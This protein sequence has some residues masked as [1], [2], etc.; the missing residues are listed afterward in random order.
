MFTNCTSAL[1][2]SLWRPSRFVLIRRF[3]HSGSVADLP[4]PPPL[5]VLQDAADSAQAREWIAKFQ[6]QEIPRNAV[7]LA[8]SRS[9]G[10]GGQN[11]NK[12]N[13]KATLRCSLNS[14][15]LPPWSK[16]YLIKST[17]Y[18]ASTHTVQITSTVYRSQAQNIQECLSKLHALIVSAA[19]AGLV[20]ETSEEQKERVRRL[21]RAAKARRRE[22]KEKRSDV[23]RA[24]RS[25]DWD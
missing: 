14:A 7:E 20:N 10:P 18:V 15:W 3:A 16:E 2:V 6:A 12:V 24:R 5:Q 23:K 11:V 22:G 13:T 21:E 1:V 8:F 19:S 9:S 25:K 17:A 4:A